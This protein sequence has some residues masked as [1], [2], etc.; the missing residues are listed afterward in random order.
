MRLSKD[1]LRKKNSYHGGTHWIKVTFDSA[2]AADRAMAGGPHVIRGY[3]VSAEPWRGQDI[4]DED[5]RAV[6]ATTENIASATASPGRSSTTLVPLIDSPATLSSATATG[7]TPQGTARNRTFAS[8]SS[9]SI[10]ALSPGSLS[11]GPSAGAITT[12]TTATTTQS[13]PASPRGS[14]RIATAKPIQLISASAAL[15]PAKTPLQRTL[16]AVPLVSWFSAGG[17]GG[18]HDALVGDLPRADD[19]AVDWD[20]AG[21]YWRF[22]WAVDQCFG[23]EFCGGKED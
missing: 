8:L 22:W 23:T 15:L 21:F 17:G 1:A 16:D 14:L 20:K 12:A 4:R 7:A 3:L 5:D 13:Q 2:E 6:P 9:S 11:P 10:T 18:A 19:G